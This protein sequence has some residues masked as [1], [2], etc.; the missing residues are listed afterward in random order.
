MYL[1]HSFPLFPFP[2]LLSFCLFPQSLSLILFSFLIY[3][4]PLGTLC[5]VLFL[6]AFIT[7]LLLVILWFFKHS[8][9]FF[10]FLIWNQ[11]HQRPMRGLWILLNIRILFSCQNFVKPSMPIIINFMCIDW[12]NIHTN[13]FHTPTRPLSHWPRV[14]GVGDSATEFVSLVNLIY[15]MWLWHMT[16]TRTYSDY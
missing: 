2:P 1:F 14:G 4:D 13:S 12:I 10:Y 7:S 9:L 3:L 6:L 5:N 16:G 11:L 8:H 15:R